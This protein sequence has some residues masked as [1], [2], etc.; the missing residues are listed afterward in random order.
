MIPV[1][2][3]WHKEHASGVQI[4]S[5]RRCEA[6]SKRNEIAGRNIRKKSEMI[7]RG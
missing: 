2:L 3:N 5:W 6:Q 7:S 4:L 1:K